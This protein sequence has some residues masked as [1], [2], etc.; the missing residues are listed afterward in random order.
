MCDHTAMDCFRVAIP[1]IQQLFGSKIV[2]TLAD[3]Q[4]VIVH[5]SSEKL[6]LGLNPG[7]PLKSQSGSYRASHEQKRIV[8]KVDKAAY[9]CPYIARAVPLYGR[10][11]EVIGAISIG[12][13]VDTQDELKSMSQILS[14]SIAKSTDTIQ[15][16]AAQ[17]QQMAAASSQLVQ[18]A[19]ES[20]R[21]AQQTDRI[22][23][24]IKNIASQTNLLGLN[25]AIEAARVG[26]HGRGF[27]V[28]A[29]EIRKLATDSTNFIKDIE[30][31]IRAIQSDSE[32]ILGQME[33][34][35]DGISQVADSITAF[36]GYNQ[37]VN[38]MSQKLDLI[39]ENLSQGD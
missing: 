36:T 14:E 15:E 8:T 9:G 18:L 31:V 4:K 33:D 38:I 25:A 3:K 2:I 21:Q 6:N 12:E 1:Y 13:T 28:V 32:A 35:N 37:Q 39:A 19:I 27:G 30:N 11:S 5:C 29:S 24:L 20:K 10:N 16:I 17:S 22:L 23:G 7:D 34:I 26:D